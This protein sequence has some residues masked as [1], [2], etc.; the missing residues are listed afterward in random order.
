MMQYPIIFLHYA[1]S[2]STDVHIIFDLKF[3]E[4]SFTKSVQVMNYNYY[5]YLFTYSSMIVLLKSSALL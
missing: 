1:D 2:Y 5:A 4:Y 3:N